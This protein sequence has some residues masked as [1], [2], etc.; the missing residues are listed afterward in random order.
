MKITDK[1]NEVFKQ[2][3]SGYIPLSHLES[4]TRNYTLIRQIGAKHGFY[5]F[6]DYNRNKSIKGYTTLSYEYHHYLKL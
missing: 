6:N 2:N 1:L 3:M 4:I 5:P